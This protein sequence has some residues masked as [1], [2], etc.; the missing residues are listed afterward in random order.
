MRNS[1]IWLGDVNLKIISVL[2]IFK[3]M[4]TSEISEEETI[5]GTELVRNRTSRNAANFE[6]GKLG[7][8]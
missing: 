7:G 5:E 6:L 8:L 1:G 3:A 4:K 2:V